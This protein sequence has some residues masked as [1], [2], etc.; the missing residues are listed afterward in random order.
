LVSPPGLL[1]KSNSTSERAKSASR[2]GH[3]LLRYFLF[4][5]I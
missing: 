3:L 4:A 5:F 1:I 2:R